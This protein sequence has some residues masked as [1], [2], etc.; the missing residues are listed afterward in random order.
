MGTS[1]V[2]CTAFGCLAEA[3]RRTLFCPACWARIAKTTRAAILNAALKVYRRGFIRLAALELAQQQGL[4]VGPLTP[5]NVPV[6]AASSAARPNSA[7]RRRQRQQQAAQHGYVS[8][9]DSRYAKLRPGWVRKRARVLDRDEHTCVYC[10]A[11]ADT[12]DHLIPVADCGSHGVE[13]LVACCR[14]CNAKKGDGP[15]LRMRFAQLRTPRVGTRSTTRAK[16]G[17][18]PVAPDALDADDLDAVLMVAD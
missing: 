4:V 2:T 14:P 13:N 9:V 8:F 17:A 12:V 11:P 7:K 6:V 18:S 10:G 5:Y 1:R 3:S 16:K 15:V